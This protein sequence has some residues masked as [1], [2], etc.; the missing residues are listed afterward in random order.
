MVDV[1]CRCAKRYFHVSKS[2][3]VSTRVPVPKDFKERIFLPARGA[4]LCTRGKNPSGMGTGMGVTGKMTS[5][6]NFGYIPDTRRRIVGC[7]VSG[8]GTKL[9][10]NCTKFLREL[11]IKWALLWRAFR[12]MTWKL[13]RIRLRGPKTGQNLYPINTRYDIHDRVGIGYF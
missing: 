4:G 7:Q 13:V 9:A 1:L 6:M 5:G 11:A 8:M 12:D 10:T 2:T 3:D